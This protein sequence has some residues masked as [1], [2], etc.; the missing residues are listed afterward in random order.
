MAPV[1]LGVARPTAPFNLSSSNSDPKELTKDLEELFS[2]DPMAPKPQT[3]SISSIG[4]SRSR[5]RSLTVENLRS[6][7]HH[8]VPNEDN[9]N[10][11]DEAM[12]EHQPILPPSQP[13]SNI[14]QPPQPQDMDAED[15]LGAVLEAGNPNMPSNNEAVEMDAV[16]GENN[17]ND[18]QQSDMDLDYLAES[19]SD[20]ETENEVNEANNANNPDNGGQGGAGGQNEVFFSDED[21]GESSHG[22]E[23]ESEAGETDEQD[24]DEFSFGGQVGGPPEELLERRSS[25]P[26]GGLGNDRANLAPQSMQ[27]AIRPRTGKARNGATSSGT[28]NGG[29]IYINSDQLRRS[30]S[31]AHA[32]AAAAV[33]AGS[34]NGGSEAVTMYTTASALARAFSVVVRTI[35]DLLSLLQGL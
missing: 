20:S 10:D 29:L 26:L 17:D 23:D 19:E 9:S 4:R 2:A 18:D 31:S 16:V 22:E 7:R 28:S 32:V 14:S 34:G 35:S 5:T 21:T 30:S 24:G 12:S 15:S 25:G 3:S 27:W 11:L 13:P 33:A 8:S 1:R 6:S